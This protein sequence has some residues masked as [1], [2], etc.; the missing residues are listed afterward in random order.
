MKI[1]KIYIENKIT[2]RVELFEDFDLIET[3]NKD[4][5][6]FYFLFK[7]NEKLMYETY[8]MEKY[9]DSIIK[10]IIRFSNNS[11]SCNS[12]PAI[13]DYDKNGNKTYQYLIGGQHVTFP[14]C[15]KTYED[16]CNYLKNYN[17]LS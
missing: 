7:I 3:R 14:E 1:I 10:Q 2:R 4:E 8:I 11:V 17:L 13:I 15:M 12:G 6:A 9:E 16:K 5:S